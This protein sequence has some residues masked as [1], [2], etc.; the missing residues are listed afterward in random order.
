MILTTRSGE[1]PTWVSEAHVTVLDL[2]AIDQ[3]SSDALA[4]CIPGAEELP[5]AV[6]KQIP[7]GQTVCLFLSRN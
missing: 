7:D 6:L 4:K 1:I 3:A 2:G 5:D